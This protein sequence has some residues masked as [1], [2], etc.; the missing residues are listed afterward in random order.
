MYGWDILIFYSGDVM[1]KG[2]EIKR[3]NFDVS[4]EQQADI[5]TLQTLLETPSKKDAVLMAVQLALHLVAET[6]KGNQ[7]F[8]GHPGEDLKRFVML[9]IEKPDVRRWMYLVEHSHPWKRQLYVKGRKLPAAAVW[10][11]I[12]TNNLSVEEAMDNWELSKA[13]V[14]E[15]VEYCETHKDLLEMEAAEEL[16]LLHE[17]GIE[18]DRPTAH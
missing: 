5:E 17:K 10:V 2:K 6:K 18:I 7:L 4:P 8:V 3:E 15:I 14:H 9:G 12:A 11:G 13:A 16:R 1:T